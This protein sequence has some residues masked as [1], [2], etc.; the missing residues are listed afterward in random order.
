[1]ELFK[2]WTWET[3]ILDGSKNNFSDDDWWALA[4][5]HGL[6]TP[7]LDWSTSPYIAAFFAYVG[8]LERDIGFSQ[9]NPEV[10]RPDFQ[11]K[12]VIWELNM[13]EEIEY[14]NEFEL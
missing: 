10:L 3:G 4:R 12:V 6:K 8:L 7:L 9:G 13:L 11:G 2:H 14:G 5:H 1:L